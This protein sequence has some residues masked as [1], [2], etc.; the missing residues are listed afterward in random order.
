MKTITLDAKI[1]NI[2]EITNF[3]DKELEEN[4]CSIKAQMQIDVAVDEVLSNIVNYAY[5][6]NNGTMGVEIDIKDGKAVISFIDSGKKY[7]PLE[8][9]DPDITLSVEERKIG[10]LGIFL[11]KKT[12]DDMRYE[13]KDDKNILTVIKTI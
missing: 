4:E 1:E 5:K 11:V 3:I 13:Y 2:T 8:K 12:M 7:N 9:D 6:G 10:G